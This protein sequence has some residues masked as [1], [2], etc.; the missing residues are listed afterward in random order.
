MIL[1]FAFLYRII[2]D[3]QWFALHP[4]YDRHTNPLK[5]NIF[6]RL[7]DFLVG[8]EQFGTRAGL[9]LLPIAKNWDELQGRVVDD[10]GV[11]KVTPFTTLGTPL[12][13]LKTFGGREGFETA[14]REL[15]EAL[16]QQVA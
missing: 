6:G 12:E 7:D 9:T 4:D 14:V 10:L 15:Q 5:D 8:M 1:F 13:L 16:Y 3:Y 2:G 11:L